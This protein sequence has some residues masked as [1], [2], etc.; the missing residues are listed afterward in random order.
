MNIFLLNLLDHGL[1]IIGLCT[2]IYVTYRLAVW[3]SR[4]NGTHR[5][6]G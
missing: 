4:R 5:S 1:D 3:W 6:Q 2:L